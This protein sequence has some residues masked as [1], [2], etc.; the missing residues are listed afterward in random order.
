MTPEQVA[1]QRTARANGAVGSK[2]V[3][4]KVIRRLLLDEYRDQDVDVLDFGCGPARAHAKDSQAWA[5]GLR[6][7]W[8]FVGYDFGDQASTLQA[9]WDIVYASNVLNV[10]QDGHMLNQTLGQLWRAQG[11]GR[12]FVNYPSGPRHLGWTVK[13]LKARLEAMGWI[14]C[15]VPGVGN[16]QVFELVKVTA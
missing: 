16:N 6:Q 8:T 7:R 10:Q 1:A 12:L 13:Q 15:K 3:L 9:P 14:V 11:Q 2:A 5:S 4:P